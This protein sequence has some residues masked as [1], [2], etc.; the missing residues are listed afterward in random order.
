MERYE[1]S[2]IQN[3][4][5]LVHATC[6]L[7]T[8]LLSRWN[9]QFDPV[10]IGQ[11]ELTL[12]SLWQNDP[13]RLYDALQWA[14]TRGELQGV[15]SVGAALVPRGILIHCKATKSCLESGKCLNAQFV[16]LALV[17]GPR[18]Y[19]CLHE[20]QDSVINWLVSSWA[21]AY[22][23]IEMAT[24]RG[25]VARVLSKD[26]HTAL[27]TDDNAIQRHLKSLIMGFIT[28]PGVKKLWEAIQPP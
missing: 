19:Q 27:S 2:L 18:L 25:L 7:G 17:A 1:T 13:S 10:V 22:K 11:A 6:N 8:S 12:P 28:N 3:L 4:L 16:P 24:L 21:P 15:S 14:V 9:R 20:T 26:L 23:Q 5:D